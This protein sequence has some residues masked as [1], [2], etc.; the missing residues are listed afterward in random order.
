MKHAVSIRNGRGRQP[1]SSEDRHFIDS[2]EIT[3]LGVLDGHGGLAVVENTH[4]HLPGK[5]RALVTGA[6]GDEEAICKGLAKVFADHDEGLKAGG[7]IMHRDTGTTATIAIVTPKSCIMAF[8][9]DS[10]ACIFDPEGKVLHA[11]RSHIPSEKDEMARIEAGGGH[12][13]KGRGGDVARV[14]GELAVSRAF[15]DFSLK[16]HVSSEPEIQVFPRPER[17]HIALMSDGLIELP[18]MIHGN[19]DDDLAMFKPMSEIAKNIAV[20]LKE[21][22]GEVAPAAELVIQRHVVEHAGTEEDYGSD[23]LTLLIC[24]IG[25]AKKSLRTATTRKRLSGG[26]AAAKR[27]RSHT[28]KKVGKV[29]YI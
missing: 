2:G 10:P 4:K 21:S 26:A 20:A 5:L 27:H 28:S 9:G 17:G 8:V 23:D 12:V 14:M 11:I 15:G 22:G 13:T 6:K 19:D 16:P 3:I 29:Y 7:R 1:P 25:L 24:D 18:P